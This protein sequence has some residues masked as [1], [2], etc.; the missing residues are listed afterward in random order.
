MEFQGSNEQFAQQVSKSFSEAAKSEHDSVDSL[1]GESSLSAL[2]SAGLTIQQIRTSPFFGRFSGFLPAAG[3]MLF[4]GQAGLF[5]LLS[6]SVGVT[7]FSCL[8]FIT[9][10]EPAMWS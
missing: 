1:V 2:K 8:G 10:T 9:T 5:W 4:A 6:V 3:G 7:R